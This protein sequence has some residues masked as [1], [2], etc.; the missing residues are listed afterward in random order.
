MASTKRYHGLLVGL[1]VVVGIVIMAA[2]ILIIGG[3]S[4]LFTPKV[5]YRTNFP[6]ASGLREGSPVTMAGVR[7]GGVSRIVLPE[8]PSSEGIEVFIQVDERFSARVREGTEA[9][10]VFLQYV[11]NEKAI[12]LNPG[13]SK[14]PAYRE[15]DFIPA[16]EAASIFETGRTVADKI[17]AITGDLQSIL[18][19]MKEGKGLLGRAIVDPDFGSDLLS[20]FSTLG[21]TLDETRRT[22]RAVRAGDG[23]TGRLIQDDELAEKVLGDVR[24][25]AAGFAEIAEKLAAPDGFI[26]GLTE[27]GGADDLIA[28]LKAAATGFREAAEAIGGGDGG[29]LAGMLLHD[30]ELAEGMKDNLSRSMEHLASIMEKIDTGQGTLGLLV[31][32]PS[33]HQNVEEV[34]TGVRESRV[35]RWL[36][37]KYHKKGEKEMKENPAEPA[38]DRGEPID[39]GHVGD[40]GTYSPRWPASAGGE[41]PAGSQVGIRETAS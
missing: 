7:V 8:N 1:V 5:T 32:D 18:R 28:D 3:E 17:D 2:M 14:L 34:I 22:L 35:A 9:H 29:G 39:A 12:D 31:N 11:A 19:D 25:A 16:A 4:Q 30:D 13:D 37:R 27:T 20:S 36:I 6:D 33:L 10:L 41:V 21:E 26:A 40:D 38:P 23:L 15:D 24:R